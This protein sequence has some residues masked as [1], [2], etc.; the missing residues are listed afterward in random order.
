MTNGRVGDRLG[1]LRQQAAVL[2][3]E[4]IVHHL[5]MRGAGADEQRVAFIGDAAQLIESAS[6]R[7]KRRRRSGLTSRHLS[8]SPFC[9]RQKIWDD[10]RFRQR[11]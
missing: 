7:Y 3:D 4:R 2:G 10:L 11:A 9:F 8:N 6:R 5:V 1:S